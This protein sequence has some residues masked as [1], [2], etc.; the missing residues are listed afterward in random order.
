MSL[1]TL[2]VG[3]IYPTGSLRIISGIQA[4]NGFVLIGWSA[5][6]AFVVMQE[7]WE[8]GRQDR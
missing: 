7:S 5:S 4:L 6:F 2:G 1:T 3:P 8:K